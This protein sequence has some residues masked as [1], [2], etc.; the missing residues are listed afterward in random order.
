M[1]GLTH[2]RRL[3]RAIALAEAHGLTEAPRAFDLLL[4]LADGR[5]GA[6]LHELQEQTPNA[7]HS[8]V[9]R[10]LSYLQR[11]E[12]VTRQR[13]PHDGRTSAFHLTSKGAV[14]AARINATLKGAR[15]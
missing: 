13:H 3:R 1:T 12:L 15:E 4:A 10:A 11:A 6:A 5:A 2:L 8:G 9:S 7:T 14:L